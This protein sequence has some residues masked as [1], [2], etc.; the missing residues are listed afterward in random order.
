MSDRLRESGLNMLLCEIV[1]CCFAGE[2]CH[3]PVLAR[4]FLAKLIHPDHSVC[5]TIVKG[6][7]IVSITLWPSWLNKGHKRHIRIF[8]ELFYSKQYVEMPPHACNLCNSNFGSSF[9]HHILYECS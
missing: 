7:T 8:N 9:W 6:K 1:K 5:G 2:A 3:A 4:H